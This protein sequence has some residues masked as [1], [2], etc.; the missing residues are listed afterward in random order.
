MLFQRETSVLVV[1]V[2]MNKTKN[3]RSNIYYKANIHMR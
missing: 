3:A 1:Y 2:E